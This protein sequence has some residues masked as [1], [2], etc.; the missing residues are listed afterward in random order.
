MVKIRFGVA[1]DLILFSDY[2]DSLLH[3][4]LDQLDGTGREVTAV[5]KCICVSVRKNSSQII[6]H[7]STYSIIFGVG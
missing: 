3:T 2:S 4:Y 7:T 1:A 5:Q 6:T